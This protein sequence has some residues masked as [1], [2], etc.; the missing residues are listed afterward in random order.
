MPGFTGFKVSRHDRAHA[1]I[2]GERAVFTDVQAKSRLALLFIEAVAGKAFVGKDRPDVAV[3]L[4]GF[5][6]GGEA[7][8]E[9]QDQPGG[10]DGEAN[11]KAH[12]RLS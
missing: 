12:G 5:G 9:A 6:G 11:A 1:V 2:V 8:K 3:E 4:D 7:R 10:Q